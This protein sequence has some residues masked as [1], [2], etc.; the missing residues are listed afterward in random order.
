MKTIWVSTKRSERTYPVE[1]VS[2]WFSRVSRIIS[3]DWKGSSVFIITDTNVRKLYGQRLLCGLLLRGIDTWLI[4]FPSGE[5]SKNADVVNILHS[6]LLER[7]VRRDSVIVA[8][9]GGVV[10]DVAGYV[11]ATVLRGITYIQVPTTLLAQVD[12]SVG[13]KVGI[14]HPLGKNLIGAF[15]QPSAVCIDPLLLRTLPEREYKSG[16]AE[17]VK[18]AAALDASFFKFLERNAA[19][20]RK[21][22]GRTLCNVIERSV[23]L[24]AAVAEKDEFETGLRKTLNLGHTL[25]HAFEAVSGYRLRHGEAVAAGL[26]AESRIARDMGLLSTK[27]FARLL[28]LMHALGLRMSLP[29]V[30]NKS[31]FLS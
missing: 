1:I 23:R 15:H 17:V 27:E 24:K 20:I 19:Q 10:G 25:G 7:G 14:D 11:A 8:L 31:E 2:E 16:L 22:N 26:V 4:D 12:S 30:K 21:R 3:R 5:Q 29:R 6:A 18:I 13:G 28:H 9:G